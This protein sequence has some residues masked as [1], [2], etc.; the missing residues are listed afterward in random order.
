MEGRDLSL[1]RISSLP[2]TIIEN[3]L[4]LVPIQDAARTSVLSK[5]WRYSWTK[6]PKLFFAIYPYPISNK[7]SIDDNPLCLLEETFEMPS[8][9]IFMSRRFKLFSAIYQVLLV[10]Q[11]PI[12][13]F[14][15]SVDAD[16]TCVEI[17]QVIS[18][19]SRMNTVKK[20]TLELSLGYKLPLSFFSLHQLTDL[21][22]VFCNVGY[23]PT[24]N[25]F[26]NLTSLHMEHVEIDKE[27][28]LRFLSNCPLLKSITVDM[29]SRNIG[30]ET[31]TTIQLFECLPVI[32]QVTFS[33]TFLLCFFQDVVPRQLTASLL[34]LE[35]VCLE[36]IWYRDTFVLPFIA[37]LLRSSP[38]LKTLKLLMDSFPPQDYSDIWLEHLN[39]LEID[40]CA[41]LKHEMEF[42]KCILAKSPVL[43]KVNI[44]LD[45]AVAK[46]EELKML[47]I[48]SRSPRASPEVD[49]NVERS[50]DDDGDVT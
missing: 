21:S 23:Q 37:L 33:S 13:D 4:C 39:E 30:F 48:I 14:T 49:I 36:G 32:E 28:L 27:T 38:N 41:S 16:E 43:K 29:V 44:V 9:R 12:L 18:Y 8:E 26:G 50:E 10:H 47:R 7:V 11:G 42:V 19:L 40:K 3:I 1:D 17:D 25:G 46:K 5:D 6:I 20:L 31:F 22:L 45:F 24:L 34:H 2:S 15:L 35:Y